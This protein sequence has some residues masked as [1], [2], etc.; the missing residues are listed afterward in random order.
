MTQ[1]KMDYSVFS[2]L[3]KLLTLVEEGK[4]P[5]VDG[6]PAVIGRPLETGSEIIDSW[7]EHLLES[8]KKAFGD[9]TRFAWIMETP[10]VFSPFVW[11]E[12]EDNDDDDDEEGQEEE[13]RKKPSQKRPAAKQPKSRTS[14]P[15]SGTSRPASGTTAPRRQASQPA[16]PPKS[17]KAPK[18]L[19][20]PKKPRKKADATMDIDEE[21][22]FVN[23]DLAAEERAEADAEDDYDFGAQS[24]DDPSSDE[25]E[26]ESNEEAFLQK[27]FRDNAKQGAQARAP[28]H[29]FGT[30]ASARR[31]GA[32][33][34][35]LA[36]SAADI[37]S[38][39]A[40]QTL[41]TP[42]EKT[43]T[44]AVSPK[45]AEPTSDSESA[46]ATAEVEITPL[47]DDFAKFQGRTAETSATRR[48]DPIT[49]VSSPPIGYWSTQSAIGQAPQIPSPP[50]SFRVLAF[51][52]PS[53]LDT[54][55]RAFKATYDARTASPIQSGY[56]VQNANILAIR[57]RA[58]WPNSGHGSIRTPYICKGHPSGRLSG[59]TLGNCRRRS[60]SSASGMARRYVYASFGMSFN[61][62][63]AIATPRA[64][65]RRRVEDLASHTERRCTFCEDAF[66]HPQYPRGFTL[67]HR[68]LQSRRP[69]T[70]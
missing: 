49:R 44:S 53:Y 50:E 70:T 10:Q 61:S 36:S 39:Q 38:N 1:K 54:H 24:S 43:S 21:L 19:P 9:P 23:I 2:S 27:V 42:A 7:A 26:S 34:S 15:V 68:H 58:C 4:L 30:R 55:G 64:V 66:N 35:T 33:P 20:G 6:R 28:T 60:S 17:V 47:E 48:P 16:A 56:L 5:K 59:P 22:E 18:R 52:H 11:Q 67:R 32:E 41:P 63:Y 62:E 45:P 51:T 8:D 46:S 31:R 57:T 12:E 29:S 69:S 25:M 40:A 3:T 37:A 14:R 13:S 65:R